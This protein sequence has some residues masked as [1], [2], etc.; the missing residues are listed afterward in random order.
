MTV[1]ATLEE[2]GP[3]TRRSS[4]GWL[5]TARVVYRMGCT[6]LDLA[7]IPDANSFGLGQSIVPVIKDPSK[8]VRKHTVFSFDVLFFLPAGFPGAHIRAIRAGER[9]YAVYFGIDGS[10]LEYELYNIKSDPLQV[11]ELAP[12][13]ARL[14]C[15]TGMVSFA[16]AAND[17]FCRRQQSARFLCLADRTGAGLKIHPGAEDPALFEPC[18]TSLG[19]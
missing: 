15:S 8:A 16:S 12:R 1:L 18:Q 3:K 6:I 2:T 17:S 10:G 13:N 7:G 4:C 5:I 19:R 11:Q 9:R 14:G